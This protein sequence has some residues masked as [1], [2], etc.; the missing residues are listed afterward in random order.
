KADIDREEAETPNAIE[1]A[2]R[3]VSESQTRA[4]TALQRLG[5]VS[6]D[7]VQARGLLDKLRADRERHAAL[8]QRQAERQTDLHR[9]E[10]MTQTLVEQ[11]DNLTLAE[12]KVRERL[13]AVGVAETGPGSASDLA[14]R[15]ERLQAYRDVTNA[16]AEPEHAR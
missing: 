7:P 9:L 4:R 13:A 16:L 5:I 14:G 15:R 11:R 8:L 12:G 1:R 3:G 6:E 2:Q 10:Q